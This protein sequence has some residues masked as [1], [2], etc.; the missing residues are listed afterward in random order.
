M[1]EPE[2]I[3]TTRSSYDAVAEEYAEVVG[4]AVRGN[5]FARAM[6]GAFAE[7]VK[8]AG[9]SRVADLGCGPGRV[10]AHLHG[11]GLDVFGVDLSSEMLAIARREQPGL[12]FEQGSMAALDVEDGSLGGLVSSYS[13][14]HTP[15]EELPAVFAEF[16]R[17]LAPGGCVLLLFFADTD[18]SQLAWPF[19]HKV[20][21][22][23][24]LSVDR[25]GELLRKAGFAE[26]A[27]LIEQPPADSER[28]FEFGHVL[29]RKPVE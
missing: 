16:H 11:L 22:A 6:M 28:G 27:R 26:V 20:T 4:D 14:I 21:L 15:P 10:T 25:V 13:I 2:F 29:V 19:D 23:Y 18:S 7:L 24:R 3:S 17:V 12:R 1:S 9:A 8:E 5:P